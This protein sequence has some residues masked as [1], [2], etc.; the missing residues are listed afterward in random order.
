MIRVKG[1]KLQ[2][3]IE[4]LEDY[5]AGGGDARYEEALQLVKDTLVKLQ[6]RSDTLSALE[7]GGVDNWEWYG[8]SLSCLDEKEE[9]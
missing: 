9:D 4:T 3:A 6:R 7:A 1:T 2:E 5:P 8:E